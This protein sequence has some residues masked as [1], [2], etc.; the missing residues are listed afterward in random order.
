MGFTRSD[1]LSQAPPKFPTPFSVPAASGD[2]VHLALPGLGSPG[3]PKESSSLLLW[4][5]PHAHFFLGLP[6]DLSKRLLSS[7]GDLP[8]GIK[9]FDS[10]NCCFRVGPQ[11]A[12]REVR[13]WI[14]GSSFSLY[15]RIKI[16]TFFETKWMPLI[17][18]AKSL[19]QEIQERQNRDGY[20]TIV[21]CK[22]Q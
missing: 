2:D 21:S 9:S 22:G 13:K 16:C 4:G 6:L 15:S 17:D 1:P 8:L 18:W 20:F 3:F 12:Y 19:Y 14:T 5:K 10:Q 11:E 7:E